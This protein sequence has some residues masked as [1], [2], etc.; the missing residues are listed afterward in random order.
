[1]HPAIRPAFSGTIEPTRVPPAYRLGL[2]VVALTMLLLPV[3]YLGLIGATGVGVW[4]HLTENTWIMSGS[5]R[6]NQW[7]LI[8]YVAPAVAGLV[9]M[10]F[11]V[12]PI[13]ARPS[14]REDPLP[15]DRI[16]EP[17]LFALI[18]EICRQVRAPRP[19]LVQVDCTVNASAGF[20]HGPLM[21][22]RQDLVLTIGLPLVAGLSIRELAGV[23][24][25]EFGHFA[26]GGGMRLTGIVRGVNAWFARVVY[27]RDEWDVKLQRWSKEIDW[28]LG[29][30]L[31][32]AR[33]AVWVSRKLLNGL[34]LGGHAISCF[35]MRQMEY[36]ADSYEIKIAGTEAFKRTSMRLRELNLAAGFAY[37]D[38]RQS[39]DA[40]TLPQ[41]LPTFMVERGRSLPADVLARVR[42]GDVERTGVFDTHPCDADRIRAAEAAGAAGVLAGEEADRD[43]TLL[44]RDFERLSV[45]ATQHHFE[46]DLGLDLRALTLVDTSVALR[47]SHTRDED[48]SALER[49]FGVHWTVYRPLRLEIA[50]PDALN[51]IDLFARHAD[52]CEAMTRQQAAVADRYAEFDALEA[53]L[54]NA[55]A[56]SE[57][58]AAGFPS[59]VPED[60]DLEAGTAAA[61]ASAQDRATRRQHTLDSPLAGFEAAAA[62]RLSCALMLS[63]VGQSHPPDHDAAA[64]AAALNALAAAIPEARVLRRLDLAARLVEANAAA[65][66]KPEDAAA[67]LRLL[68]RKLAACRERLSGPLANVACPS[69]FATSPVTLAER[70]GVPPG[71]PFVPAS[72]IVDRV[73]TI[74]AEVLGR[75]IGLASKVEESLTATSVD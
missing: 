30:V 37:N 61:A 65:S 63:G 21:L 69:G 71:G 67:H 40:G 35:M 32:M 16:A 31:G 6:S 7:R 45:A 23:L 4:W 66:P 54:Q 3:F 64:L 68:E 62:E 50:E 12:K 29:I 55:V 2:A 51:A 5:G 41:S 24:A 36:D 11:M 34:M 20:V 8:A 15:V 70:C 42:D 28:R 19:R 48:Y 17:A 44:F 10:F 22:L 25:H 43:A 60:F 56:A 14:R 59:V 27:E 72:E 18:D 74:Y 46:H 49:F 75:L 38:L 47:Q 57:L 39:L 1:M 33:A 52:A 26:Q 13:L 73:F 58:L 9:L 53:K